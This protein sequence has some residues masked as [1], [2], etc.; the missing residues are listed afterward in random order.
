MMMMMSLRFY[1][2][3]KM[4]SN[5]TLQLLTLALLTV[6]VNISSTLSFF[7]ISSEIKEKNKIYVTVSLNSFVF[8]FLFCF[9]PCFSLFFQEIFNIM[10]WN[11]M[12]ANNWILFKLLHSYFHPSP[13]F[14]FCTC[15]FFSGQPS[16]PF[17]LGWTKKEFFC[18]VLKS[19][20]LF[21]LHY[22]SHKSGESV[23][24][25]MDIE[26]ILPQQFQI[27]WLKFKS[28]LWDFSPQTLTPPM[29]AK[30]STDLKLSIT[31]GLT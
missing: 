11:Y 22:V 19:W 1:S 10:Y 13:F 23:K 24:P 20:S 12:G 18:A 7:A 3:T 30:L 16:M 29:K 5:G 28:N 8:D 15:F 2:P 17:L 4:F 25:W 14:F 6:L 21:H 27:N 26:N 9:F 31:L